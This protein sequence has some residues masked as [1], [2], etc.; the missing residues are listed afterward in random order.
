MLG[1]SEIKTLRLAQQAAFF[2]STMRRLLTEAG[3]TPGMSVLDLGSGTGDVAMLAAEMVGPSG[4]VVGVD[5]NP[6]VLSTARTR[7]QAA[8]LSQTTF[9]TG[10][11]RNLD[12]R[13][14]FDAVIGRFVLMYPRDPAAALRHALGA[15][16][17]N[18]LA[19]F[20]EC[21][22]LAGLASF[23]ES[24]LHQLVG[25]CVRET[26]AASGVELAMGWKLYQTSLTR[27]CDH[28]NCTRTASSLGANRRTA[29]RRTLRTCFEV[30]CRKLWNMGSRQR[31]K[32][33][34]THSRS[35]M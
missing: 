13:Q 9:I 6:A 14:E 26:F 2:E 35:A 24:R 15:R 12:L 31:T 18:G 20:Y 27:G 8:G 29:S 7:A 32:S 23:P 4:R 30:S 28:P 3:M 25:C 1:R 22:L 10:D 33:P 16:R 5:S 17:P 34:S 21:N 19:V 11:I